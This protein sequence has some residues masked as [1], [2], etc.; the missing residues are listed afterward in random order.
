MKYGIIFSIFFISLLSA[1]GRA[2]QTT[3]KVGNTPLTQQYASDNL[4]DYSKWLANTVVN[5]IR[6][7][8]FEKELEPKPI[9]GN[10][11]AQQESSVCG[12]EEDTYKDNDNDGDSV[13]ANFQTTF[14]SC[15]QDKGTYY[16]IK[17]GQIWIEDADDNEVESGMRS[18]ATDLIFDFYNRGETGSQDSQQLRLEDTWDV[19]VLKNS[20]RGS[21]SYTLTMTAT[22]YRRDVP[23]SVKGVLTVAGVYEALA[24]K[25]SV[26]DNNDYDNAVIE[27][28]SGE[29]LINDKAAF[30]VTLENL[31]FAETCL[32]TPVGGKF[33]LSDNSNTF[34]L[35]FAG[36]ETVTYTYNGSSFE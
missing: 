12:F 27:S 14:V 34:T 30:S 3:P 35:E 6:S 1:C 24:D 22:D 15:L 9:R 17:N 8:A 19:T 26:F 4:K 36:C 16:E 32:A 31:Q 21:L 28:A 25:D 2:P 20:N 23:A 10:L 11:T 5:S 33:K 18:R 29:L 7:S 13:Q